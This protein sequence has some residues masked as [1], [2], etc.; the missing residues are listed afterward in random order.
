MCAPQVHLFTDKQEK[1]SVPLGQATGSRVLDI[2]TL[3]GVDKC[4][5]VLLQG[6]NTSNETSSLCPARARDTAG[7]APA[8]PGMQTA[9]LTARHFS[10]FGAKNGGK[11]I[12]TPDIQLAK[13]ALYQLSYAPVEETRMSNVEIRMQIQM[14][15]SV[16][17][18]RHFKSQQ[19][20][21][22]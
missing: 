3:S 18:I 2:L 10:L 1:A 5:P 16:E 20:N 7:G 13:L 6:S 12:R 8:L 9:G 4:R 14:P 21:K 15:D 17:A 11:G 19:S 22:N